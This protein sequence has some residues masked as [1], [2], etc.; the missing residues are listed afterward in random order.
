[1]SHDRGEE[2]LCLFY[3]S[4]PPAAILGGWHLIQ[5][6]ISELTYASELMCPMQGHTEETG[7]LICQIL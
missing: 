7:V 4:P 3:N 1:M 6:G 2:D 5:R